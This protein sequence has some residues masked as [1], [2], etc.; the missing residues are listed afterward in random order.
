MVLTGATRPWGGGLVR[1]RLPELEWRSWA[2]ELRSQLTRR[3][4]DGVAVARMLKSRGGG[5]LG[6]KA[7]STLGSP[8]SFPPLLPLAPGSW[9]R[10]GKAQTEA[11]SQ[12]WPQTRPLLGAVAQGVWWASLSPGAA[13]STSPG[14]V[15][16][17]Y[18]DPRA[19]VPRGPQQCGKLGSTG[20]AETISPDAHFP[21]V[22]LSPERGSI[23]YPEPLQAQGPAVEGRAPAAQLEWNSHHPSP[24]PQLSLSPNHTHA[25]VHTHTLPG[26]EN[27]PEHLYWGETH[28]HWIDRQ[29]RECL[30]V[31]LCVQL[32]ECTMAAFVFLGMS[33]Y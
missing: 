33:G 30:C 15:R 18:A 22:N 20:L 27:S 17:W 6:R 24:R 2:L 14:S 5:E 31:G 26:R 23:K 9:Q 21:V 1:E 4:Q 32:S 25:R 29:L 10:G 8:P 3:A 13:R 28:F 11:G 19:H 7:T 12:V 16:T